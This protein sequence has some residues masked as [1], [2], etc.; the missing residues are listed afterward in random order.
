MRKLI[1]IL[2][3]AMLAACVT[4]PGKDAFSKPQVA[5]LIELGFAPAGENYELDFN[6]R[7]LFDVDQSALNAEAS[8]VLG[9]LAGTLLKVEIRGAMVVGHTDSTGEAD[10]NLGLSQRRAA[11]VKAGL[12]AAGLDP[13]R[14]RDLGVGETQ[15][16]A[17]NETAEGRAQNRRV[18]IVVSPQDAD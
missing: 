8:A 3:A 14:V 10:Y 4:V 7:V 16:V 5:A 15:P 18:V 12:I 13:A 9:R 2:L 11:A 1:V 17:S 6:D